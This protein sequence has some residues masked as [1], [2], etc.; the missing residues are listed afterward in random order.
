MRL[1]KWLVDQGVAPARRKADQLIADGRV[2]VDGRVAELGQDVGAQANV[3]VDGN[4]IAVVADQAKRLIAYHKPVGEICSHVQQGSADTIFM[5]L[6][7]EFEHHKIIGRLDKDSEG[8]VLL[9]N[10]G[11]LAYAMSHPSREKDKRYE[12]TLNRSLTPGEISRLH[13]GVTVDGEAW[14]LD[15][16]RAIDTCCY[17]VILHEGKNR[18]IRR[19]MDAVG[20]RVMRLLRTTIDTYELGALKPG[21]WREET[22][23]G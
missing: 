23:H 17:E 1:N 21:A 9:T 13:I 22:I 16:V 11:M 15:T 2:S 3:C 14:R 12:V 7:H 5:H 4:P 8:L 10:D 18:H 19:C 20:A 6:P